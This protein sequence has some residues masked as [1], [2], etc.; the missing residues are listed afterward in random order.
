MSNPLCGEACVDEPKAITRGASGVQVSCGGPDGHLLEVLP[1]ILDEVV[2]IL[3]YTEEERGQWL[4]GTLRKKDKFLDTHT[5][6]NGWLKNKFLREPDAEYLTADVEY[7]SKYKCEIYHPSVF[8]TQQSADRYLDEERQINFVTNDEMHNE[9]LEI[10]AKAALMLYRSFKDERNADILSRKPDDNLPSN[11]KYNEFRKKS[12]YGMWGKWY[13][14]D[15]GFHRGIDIAFGSGSQIY[16]ICSGVVVPSDLSYGLKVKIITPKEYAT[17][18]Y[19]TYMH[20]NFE[21]GGKTGSNMIGKKIFVGTQIGTESSKGAPGAPHT[22]IELNYRSQNG[23]TPAY[24]SGAAGNRRFDLQ[25]DGIRS[26]NPYH[27][28][29]RCFELFHRRAKDSHQPSPPP[30]YA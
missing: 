22:H 8:D 28:I 3:A 25:K 29:S 1:L 4:D 17:D 24:T 30:H 2:H 15:L 27:F 21:I 14:S 10:A 7:K 12:S 23:Y 9:R 13:S 26:W 16:S 18:W 11:E 5:Q 6:V 19:L 20:A